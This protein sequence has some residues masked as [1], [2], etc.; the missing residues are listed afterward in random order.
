MGSNVSEETVIVKKESGGD[1]TKPRS[2]L[3]A[4][5]L[6]QQISSCE[7]DIP[8]NLYPSM[9]RL[10]YAHVA[11]LYAIQTTM[12]TFLVSPITMLVLEKYIH[13]FGKSQPGIID[14]LFAVALSSAPVVGFAL[15]FSLV[16][17][18]IYIKA[19]ITKKLI[20]LYINP[21]IVMKFV[22]TLF[23]FVIFIIAQNDI[24]TDQNIRAVS[25]FVYDC[26]HMLSSSLA[27]NAYHWCHDLLV[28]IK[29]VLIKSA[30][31]SS[32]V[33]LSCTALIGAAYFKAYCNSWLIDMFSKDFD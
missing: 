27:L 13:V 2:F 14:K 5:S 21:Y 10:Q 20:S 18:S 12:I 16:L 32:V 19:K 22:M 25:R 24:L 29:N 6:I 23:M 9:E 15:L 11:T 8:P 30:V 1:T 33:H 28:E 7:I 3:E 17:Q 26:I 4:I 31:Y